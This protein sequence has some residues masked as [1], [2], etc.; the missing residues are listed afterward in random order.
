MKKQKEI[1]L[2]FYGNH[3]EVDKCIDFSDQTMTL[4][5]VLKEFHSFLKDIGFCFK[6]NDQLEVTNYIEE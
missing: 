4:D 6:L 5:V 3:I 1:R 2:N